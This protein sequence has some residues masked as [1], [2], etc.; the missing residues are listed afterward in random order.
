MIEED[1]EDKAPCSF[2]LQGALF[3]ENSESVQREFLQKELEGRGDVL[4]VQQSAGNGL[5]SV[6]LPGGVGQTAQR[7]PPFI[8]ITAIIQ[9]GTVSPQQTKKKRSAA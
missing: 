7:G 8:T 1:E 4:T 3:V 6:A 2:A 5:R 9:K